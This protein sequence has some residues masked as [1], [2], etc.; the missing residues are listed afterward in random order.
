MIRELLIKNIAL[1][2]QL[3][4]SFS[5]GFSV[6]TGETGAG[7]SI[8]I[9]AIGLVLGE[10]AS[11]EMIRSGCDE[12][13]VTGVFEFDR[14]FPPAVAKIL[15]NNQI[16]DAD[17]QLI[18]R[19]K[20]NKSGRNRCY[21]NQQPVPLATVKTMGEY[22]V[23]LHGQHE[24]QSLLRGEIARDII[25]SL[26]E[27]NPSL[28]HYLELYESYADA[29]EALSEHERRAAEIAKRRDLIE[30]QHNELASLNLKQDEESELEQ[31][32]ALLSSST[33]R[34]QSIAAIRDTI[35]GGQAA[36]SI[37]RG[38]NQIRKNLEILQK[39]D[40]AATPWIDDVI[41]AQETIAELDRFCASY[42]D[43]IQTD[44]NRLDRLNQRLAKIQR[45]KKK[46]F[47][48]YAGLLA[49]REQLKM[50]LDTL[51]NI[52]S[53][54]SLLARRLEESE[55]VCRTAAAELSINRQSAAKE[56][57]AAICGQMSRL[58]F[59]KGELK[60]KFTSLHTLT[61]HG[62]EDIS[63]EVR[64]NP[65]EPFLPLE[66]TASGGEISRLMLAIK[67]VLAEKDKIPV[68]IFDEIDTGIGGMLAKEV[69]SSLSRLSDSHQV[70]CISHL[71]QIASS[72]EEHF[73][74]FKEHTDSRT[75]TRVRKLSEK[76]KVDEISRMLG[77]E[78]TISRRHA[79]E[80]V[81]QKKSKENGI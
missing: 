6:F 51:E 21:I 72:A 52:Q 3:R 2:D 19:R 59:T 50:E 35:E 63:F 77:S 70:I 69:A 4:I 56:F 42:G 15:E 57:D 79:E 74:V 26:P 73:H 66:K 65:G 45:L 67:T 29:R 8:L 11:S 40:P 46:Y 33:E 20:I 55:K 78:S 17:G 44:P 37:E 75:V 38:L 14:G 9:G 68:L 12:A 34:V 24:H 58:G 30:F 64:T 47:C 71:H 41:R 23:D 49:K 62:V 53:D 27:V 36:P 1:I 31:Q 16:D 76:E 22:L 5:E 43:S 25:D 18:I 10:R 32:I 28:K 48:D 39:F 7:K 54:R 80:L 13:E 61:P 60:T 81:K